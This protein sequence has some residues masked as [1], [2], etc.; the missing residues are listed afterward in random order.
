MAKASASQT[1]ISKRGLEICTQISPIPK[2]LLVASTYQGHR[3]CH[4]VPLPEGS[5][6]KPLGLCDVTVWPRLKQTIAAGCPH[7]S[8]LF[9]EGKLLQAGS[10]IAF[11]TNLLRF[12]KALDLYDPLRICAKG[13]QSQALCP[14]SCFPLCST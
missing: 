6:Q 1:H 7:F 13:S 14:N 4:Q 11:A 5:V 8:D 2:L 3:F 9:P 12:I 10:R